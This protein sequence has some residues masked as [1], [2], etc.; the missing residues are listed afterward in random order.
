MKKA[1][2]DFAGIGDFLGHCFTHGWPGAERICLPRLAYGPPLI[3]SLVCRDREWRMPVAI[4]EIDYF[5]TVQMDALGVMV[6]RNYPQDESGSL[7]GFWLG[8]GLPLG[9]AIVAARQYEP[10]SWTYFVGNRD[11]LR[12]QGR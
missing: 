10:M 8:L 6:D 7:Y 3:L 1:V 4:E 11:R 5:L 9:Q 2:F 12:R